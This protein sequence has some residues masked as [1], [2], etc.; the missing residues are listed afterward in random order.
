MARIQGRV[1]NFEDRGGATVFNFEDRG[2]ASPP[3]VEAV[4]LRTVWGATVLNLRTVGA[5]DPP[6]WGRHGPQC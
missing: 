6:G 2:G 5:P 3:W 1:L 4:I